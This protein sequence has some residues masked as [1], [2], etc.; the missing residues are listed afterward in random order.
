MSVMKALP[1]VNKSPPTAGSKANARGDECQCEDSSSAVSLVLIPR[2]GS[3]KSPAED[4]TDCR[5]SLAYDSTEER[6]RGRGGVDSRGDSLL[7]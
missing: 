3:I 6:R 7:T 4:W 5:V 1:L 2:P